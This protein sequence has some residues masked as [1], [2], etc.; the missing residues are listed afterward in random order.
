MYFV[1]RKQLE[2]TL[3]YMDCLLDQVDGYSFK[4]VAERLGLERIV[5][6]TIESMLDCGNMMIDGF[7][8]RDP[9]SFEDIIDILVDEEVL[10]AKEGENYK[11][12]IQLRR[13]LV[14]DYLDIDHNLLLKVMKENHK[15]LESFSTRIR[16]YLDGGTEVANAFSTQEEKS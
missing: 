7:I 2:R 16:N 14:K 6:M 10:P 8:M 11:A 9:G 3:L 15:S 12:V 13:M 4:T 1:D 5:H